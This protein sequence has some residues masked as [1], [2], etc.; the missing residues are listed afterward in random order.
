MMV[1][2]W[3]EIMIKSLSLMYLHFCLCEADSLL[4]LMVGAWFMILERPLVISISRIKIDNYLI[5]SFVIHRKVGSRDVKYFAFGWVG[6][7]VLR[8]RTS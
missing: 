3:M 2:F 4:I 7:F 5:A 6:G 8:N 1:D